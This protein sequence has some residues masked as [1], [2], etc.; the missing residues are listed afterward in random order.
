M[1]S[2][3]PYRT[4]PVRAVLVLVLVLDAS[5]SF[6][7]YED[8]YEYDQEQA[9][10]DA[11]CGVMVTRCE[12]CQNAVAAASGP[13]TAQRRRL[14]T[15]LR[16]PHWRSGPI[17]ECQRESGRYRACGTSRRARVFPVD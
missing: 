12:P 4:Q 1:S 17:P 3:A 10:V 13:E 9:L 5:R 15:C 8:E 7:E 6:I 2:A 14:H 11:S 16:C